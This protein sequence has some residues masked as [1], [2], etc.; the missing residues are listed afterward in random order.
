MPKDKKDKPLKIKVKGKEVIIVE[1]EDTF[2]GKMMAGTK[3]NIVIKTPFGKRKV[4]LVK[5]FKPGPK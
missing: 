4:K 2:L 5:K 1:G 3:G